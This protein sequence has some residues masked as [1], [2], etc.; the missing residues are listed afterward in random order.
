VVF[1]DPFQGA[2]IKGY[3]GEIVTFCN[4]GD[5]VCTG[6]FEVTPS[7]LSYSPGSSVAS[8]NKL[9]A[10]YHAKKGSGGGAPASAELSDSTESSSPPPAAGG[11]PKMGKGKG[12][13]KGGMRPVSAVDNFSN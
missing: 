13:G 6:N 4:A 8:F 9:A 5:N 12:K 11:M 7:H 3:N 2:K 10:A 1:G